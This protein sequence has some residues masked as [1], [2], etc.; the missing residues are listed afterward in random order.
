MNTLPH[1]QDLRK[2]LVLRG[3]GSLADAILSS[4][5]YREIKKANPKIKITVASFGPA[6]ELFKNNSYVDKVVRLPVSALTEQKVTFHLLRKALKLRLKKFDLVLD[7]SNKNFFAWQLFKK[8][9]G[10]DKLLDAT[11]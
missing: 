7:S 3:D 6:Y 5:C 8:I 9:A 11:T 10:G 2:I 1:I 4:C